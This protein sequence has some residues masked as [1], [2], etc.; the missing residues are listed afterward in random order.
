MIR[1][2]KSLIIHP[3]TGGCLEV[4]LI[5]EQ[6]HLYACMWS[7]D[8]YHKKKPGKTNQNT[9][10]CMNLRISQFRQTISYEINF[11]IIN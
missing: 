2:Y 7:E 10:T 1:I 11:Q 8:Y 5:V 4:M 3:T 9:C 6:L